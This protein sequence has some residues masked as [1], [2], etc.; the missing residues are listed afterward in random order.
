MTSYQIVLRSEG[1]EST[2]NLDA[3]GYSLMIKAWRKLEREVG[4]RLTFDA[5]LNLA[6]QRFL[7]S[8][9][10]AGGGTTF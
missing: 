5:F 1:N 4:A 7:A 3:E 8:R 10:G 2:I 9:P 6:C